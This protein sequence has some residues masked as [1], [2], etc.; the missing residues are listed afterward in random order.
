[1]ISFRQS[2]TALVLCCS[3]AHAVAAD[4]GAPEVL[5]ASRHD[6]SPP[7]SELIA[8]PRQAPPAPEEEFEIPNILL[9]PDKLVEFDP[10]QVPENPLRNAGDRAA[11]GS[12]PTLIESFDGY[13][14][15]DNAAAGVG[16]PLPPDTNGDIGPDEI[17]L[18]VNLGWKILD[19]NGNVTDGPFPGNTFWQGFGGPCETNNAGDPIVLYDKIAERWLFSQFVSSSNP[20]GRQCV[21]VSATADPLG[22]YNRYEFTFPGVFNDYPKIG[23]WTDA[24]GSRSG[25]YLTTHDFI[26]QP[27]QFLQN[28]F[29]VMER[30]AML[31]GAPAAEVDF[32]RFTD[33]ASAVDSAFG[34]LPPHLE[35]TAVPPAGMCAP[36]VHNE[37]AVDSYLIWN[38]CVNWDNPGSSSLSSPRFIPASAVFDN[39][40][41]P[42]PQ[43]DGQPGL[44]SFVPNT[45]YRASVR[46][47]DESSGL[48]PSMVI[49]HVTNAGGG[50]HGVRWAHLQ[51]DGG[52]AIFANGFEAGP[53]R[54]FG[55]RLVND[56]V[57][58]PD[59]TAR[60]MGA[61][62][63]DRSGNIGLGFSASDDVDTFP[64]VRYAGREPGT[65]PNSMLDE[66]SCVAG[67][68]AQTSTSNRWGDYA[69]TS[70]DPADQCTFWHINEYYAATASGDWS[71]R[72]CSFKFDSCGNP[73]LIARPAS[74]P[75]SQR[76]ALN[77]DPGF[78][79]SVHEIN[80]AVGD[81]TL[82]G[83]S[84]PAGTSLDFSANPV[85]GLP[86]EVTATLTGGDGLA[87]GD[88]A[89]T[90]QASPAD[91]GTPQQV[92]F[93][94]SLSADAPGAIALQAPADGADTTIRPTL[95]W[96]AAS[97]ALRYRVEIA[98][99]AGFTQLVESAEVTDTSY[100]PQSPLAATQ[101]FFWRVTA[102]N[103]CGEGATSATSSFTTV[104]PGSCPA[105]TAP[106]VV[107]DDDVEGG[108]NGWTTPASGVGVNTWTR[109]SDRFES[110]TTA[111]F[112]EDPDSQSDQFLVSP[113]IAVPPAAQSPVTLE[114]WNFQNMES[115]NGTGTDACWDG[116]LLEIS[117]DGGGSWQ[118]VPDSALL[119][120]PYNGTITD[121]PDSPISG[122]PAW[123]ADADNQPG[124]G[125]QE[126]VSIV[127]LA[128]WA[129]QTVN[130][131]YRL[132][133]DAFVGREG[134][135]IDDV[136]VQGCQ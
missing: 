94:F 51:L 87:S 1:M 46:A 120:D 136:S 43:P 130:F 77:G 117:T 88:Y 68:G 132:G 32:V 27:Q 121:N 19:K 40:V 55:E 33:T 38:L 9:D 18:Y 84:L 2:C 16:S 90:V 92:S 107:F 70:I 97:D 34:A 118:Q 50:V 69:T 86:S 82:S 78:L 134:W 83:A 28:S 119:T 66:Q 21:A 39:N 42:A 127:D 81:V 48:D 59:D 22:P 114:F 15:G 111:W 131:R 5:Q 54:A 26:I 113:A 126:I 79:V 91:A 63:M 36:F 10:G 99:D 14:Q 116:G 133:S 102:L 4:R 29:S 7:L 13:T 6:V 47:F 108:V 128:A 3:A 98:E 44:D 80:G 61:I 109:Q 123:C 115:N 53:Q 105:G 17:I 62:S 72:V 67:G 76:C 74:E 65:A 56:G 71:T 45:M 37:P 122:R 35:S 73:G 12:A 103:N 100:V 49:N 85:S 129:G 58:S 24:A 93:Q 124:S 60:W 96:D 20:D 110:P 135:Y 75:R 52:D 89:F 112:A 23:I 125:E 30:D 31:A 8:S 25:Y 57:F 64:S 106:N 11:L 41:G 95:D 101:E 104:A